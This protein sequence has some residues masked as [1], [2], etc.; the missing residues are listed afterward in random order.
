MLFNRNVTRGGYHLLVR[1]AIILHR[2]G[3]QWLAGRQVRNRDN[4]T[5]WRRKR[6]IGEM[7]RNLVML[8]RRLVRW[9][10]LVLL[11]AIRLQTMRRLQMHCIVSSNLQIR[12]CRRLFVSFQRT[13]LLVQL[14]TQVHHHS[15]RYVGLL[16]VIVAGSKSILEVAAFVFFAPV[17]MLLDLI[18][19]LSLVGLFSDKRMLQ[20][21]FGEW[22]LGVVLHQ[23]GLDES[24][25]PFR[26]LFGLEPRRRISRY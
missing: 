3:R 11:V 26:P 25:E 2:N 1:L 13:L 7:R 15:R 10:R 9:A 23:N 24:L 8:V 18:S 5:W 22:S 21:L 16:F 19:N 4:S 6:P 20:E 14:I 17:D 12:R